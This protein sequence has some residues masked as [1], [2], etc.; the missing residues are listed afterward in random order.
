MKTPKQEAFEIL[1]RLPDD[2]SFETLIAQLHFK[3]SV[4]RGLAEARRGEGIPHEE[5][6]RR[7]EMWLESSGRQRLSET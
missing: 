2:V 7:L 4:L 3:A 5:V 6:E 1:A